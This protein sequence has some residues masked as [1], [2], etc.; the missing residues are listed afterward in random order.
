MQ[1]ESALKVITKIRASK[2]HFGMLDA[3]VLFALAS[4][5]AVLEVSDIVRL[6][7]EV[8]PTVSRCISRLMRDELV[9]KAPRPGDQRRVVVTLTSKGAALAAGIA[10]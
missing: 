5:D 4:N 9:R 3:Q 6:V 10:A 8:K 2:P 7:N 1:L